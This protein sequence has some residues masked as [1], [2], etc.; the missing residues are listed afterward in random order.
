MA[1]IAP[2][3]ATEG[4]PPI[5]QDWAFEFKWDGYRAIAEVAGGQLRLYSWPGN[6]ITSSYPEIG[7]LPTLIGDHSAIFDGE[8]VA[9]DDQ[10]TPQLA[11]IQRRHNATPRTALLRAF[12]VSYYVFDVLELDGEPLLRERYQRRRELLRELGLADESKRVVV[13][14]SFTAPVDGAT[15]LTVARV[16]GL[17]GVVSK[18]L[19]S[20]Y[21]PGRRSPAWIK[22][23]VATEAF[24]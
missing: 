13:T 17:E 12:P 8:L 11:R 1:F 6:N 20:I 19:G 9:L 10:G 23:K 21:K 16:H 4:K 7:G 3:L 2:M 14:P 5:G 22:T 24:Q 18:R 15:L